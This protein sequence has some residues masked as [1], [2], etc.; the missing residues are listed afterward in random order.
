MERYIQLFQATLKPDNRMC[1]CGMLATELATLPDALSDEVRKFFEDNESWLAR[2]LGE[3]RRMRSIDFEGSPTAASR[4]MY[5]SL[6]GAM[7]SARVFG[8]AGR[9]SLTGRWLLDALIAP[10]MD[11]LLPPGQ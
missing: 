4:F 1:M 2:V 5:A 11:A 3:G 6:Q 7:I 9:L 8:D 10:M